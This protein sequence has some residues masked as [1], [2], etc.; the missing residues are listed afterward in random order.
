LEPKILLWDIEAT[1]LVGNIGNI[2]CIGYKWYGDK[3]PTVLSIRDYERD[4]KRD[5]TDDR[6]LVKD[7]SKLI[8]QADVMVTWFGKRFDM[9]FLQTRLLYHGLPPAPQIL[10]VDGW[11]IAKKKL[12]LHSNRLAAVQDFLELPSSKTPLSFRELSRSRAGHVPSLRSIEHH[13]YMDVEVLEQAY[14]KLR[15]IAGRY[16]PNTALIRGRPEA[17]TACGSE[18]IQA[19]GYGYAETRLYKRYNCQDCGAWFRGTAAMKDAGV[20]VTRV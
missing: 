1:N 17:C 12:K 5:P 16:H 20:K 4:F 3:K 7:F 19:R 2:L 10:H 14:T 15:P 8:E 11:E 6:R 9:P 13:C 18:H